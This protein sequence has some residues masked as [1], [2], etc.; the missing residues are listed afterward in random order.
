MFQTIVEIVA[1]AMEATGVIVVATGGAVAIAGFGRR[2]RDGE[3]F[4]AEAAVL[5]ERLARATLLGL[6]FLVAAD[7]IATITTVPTFKNLLM[8][9]GIVLLRTFLSATLMLEVEGRWPWTAVKRSLLAKPTD[10]PG[11]KALRLSMRTSLATTVGITS[12]LNRI[13]GEFLEMPGLRLT[14]AQAARLWSLDGLSSQA[15]LNDLTTSGFLIKTKEGAY[16]H[17]SQA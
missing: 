3:A 8:L 1:R 7:L 6:E 12:L 16:V 10:A 17:A 4:E 5:R 14:P 15:L 13:R 9:T 2:L 11:I